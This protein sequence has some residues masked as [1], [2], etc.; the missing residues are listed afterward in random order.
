MS[1][2]PTALMDPR[3]HINKVPC[4]MQV[5]FSEGQL[6]SK[7]WV[8]EIIEATS[9][10]PKMK[11]NTPKSSGSGAVESDESFVQGG[12]DDAESATVPDD[13]D[14]D[15]RMDEDKEEFRFFGMM[16]SANLVR[17]LNGDQW[18]TRTGRHWNSFGRPSQAIPRRSGVS[19]P[20]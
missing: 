19:K 14:T 12:L 2:N 4:H 5:M 11:F 6:T 18:R 13:P 10:V 1:G 7:Q 3:V 8:H 15:N 20:A 17:G 16:S 9:Y